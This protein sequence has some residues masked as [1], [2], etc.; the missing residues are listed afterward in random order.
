[1]LGP[2]CEE[3]ALVVGGGEVLVVVDLQHPG[4]IHSFPSSAVFGAG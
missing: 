4:A 3:E 1:V 2:R